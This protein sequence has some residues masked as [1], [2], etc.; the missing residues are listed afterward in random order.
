MSDPPS[1]LAAHLV[2]YTVT[3]CSAL[4]VFDY[5]CT[6]D[7]EIT[8]VWSGPWTLANY[9]YILNRYLP[10]IDTLIILDLM[11]GNPAPE[12][13][14]VRLKIATWFIVGGIMIAEVILMLRTY[15]IW[16]RRR[17]IL[18]ILCCNTFLTFLPSIVVTQIELA[19]LHYTSPPFPTLQACMADRGSKIIIIAYILLVVSETTIVTLTLIKAA[20]HIRGTSSNWVVQLYTDGLLFYVYL[21]AISL[22]SILLPILAPVS[23]FCLL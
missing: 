4:L 12:T 14:L 7:L 23:R 8:Y 17:P 18:I 3:A 22:A 5:L 16:E 20:R 11:T 10:F 21:F 19:S 13:C 2:P 15:A 9:L 1:L 6:L